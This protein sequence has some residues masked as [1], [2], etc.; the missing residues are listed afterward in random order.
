MWTH[1]ITIVLL[2]ALIAVM[3]YIVKMVLENN[4][5]VYNISEIIKEL[6]HGQREMRKEFDE[7]RGEH[8][9]MLKAGDMIAKHDFSD[10]KKVIT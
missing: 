10:K 4:K 6:Q 2:G 9:M 1:P 5:I 3:G 7:L 8:T